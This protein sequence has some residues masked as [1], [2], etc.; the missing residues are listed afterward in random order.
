LRVGISNVAQPEIGAA[1]QAA[2]GRRPGALVARALDSGVAITT[3]WPETVGEDRAFAARGAFELVGR[4]AIVVDA[5]TALTVD[6]LR[7]DRA[8]RG[9]SS[10]AERSRQARA[11]WPKPSRS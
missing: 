9:R 10:S 7:V 6:A 8:R 5:G 11:P 1:L 4:S 2:L 3:E